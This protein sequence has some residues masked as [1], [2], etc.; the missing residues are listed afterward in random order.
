MHRIAELERE[1]RELRSLLDDAVRRIRQLEGSTPE[2]RQAQ[3]EADLA[4]A[5]LAESGYGEPW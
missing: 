5:D 1:T 4:A 3:Y 2:A